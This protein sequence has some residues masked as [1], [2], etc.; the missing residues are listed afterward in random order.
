MEY[1]I[2]DCNYYE[3]PPQDMPVGNLA[4]TKNEI[5]PLFV[6]SLCHTKKTCEALGGF[7]VLDN[8]L[9]FA[10]AFCSKKD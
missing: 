9:L 8:A 4:I 7:N 2:F 5:E 1:V 10:Y 3:I 6:V